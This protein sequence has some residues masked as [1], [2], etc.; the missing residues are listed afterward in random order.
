M[1]K[2]LFVTALL[3][4]IA[5]SQTSAAKKAIVAPM[6]DQDRA[7]CLMREDNTISVSFDTTEKGVKNLKTKFDEK[8]ALIKSTAKAQG[9]NISIDNYNY[10]IS[11]DY[12]TPNNTDELEAIYRL[13]G[14]ISFK[15]DSSQKAI[16]LME[17]LNKKKFQT[18]VSVS[19]YKN[20]C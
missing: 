15:V 13:N 4:T 1:K 11:K 20:G 16:A 14:S 3:I 9:L 5:I 18:S 17:E 19:A 8:V 12:N 7:S 10:N 6:Q 2:L